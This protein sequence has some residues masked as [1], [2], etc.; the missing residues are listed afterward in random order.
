MVMVGTKD[1]TCSRYNIADKLH[2]W[3]QSLTHS[4]CKRS[5]NVSEILKRSDSHVCWLEIVVDHDSSWITSGWWFL[6]VHYY[7]DGE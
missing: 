1:V 5:T 7:V 3:Q 2:I 6:S 4:I